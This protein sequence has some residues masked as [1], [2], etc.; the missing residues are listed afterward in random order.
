VGLDL[1]RAEIAHEREGLP[2]TPLANCVADTQGGIG[3]LIQQALNNRLAA[4]GEQKAVTVVTQVE[5]DKNDPGFTHPTKPIGAFFSEAQR[6][7]LQRRTRTGILSRIQAGAIVAWWP[8]RSRCA[9]SRPMP[10]RR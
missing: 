7:E 1:R 8:H 10:S 2:L 4:R 9:L 6:D 5:V 3:Y